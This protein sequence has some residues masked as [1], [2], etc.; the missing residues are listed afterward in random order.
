MVGEMSKQA[1]ASVVGSKVPTQS[2]LNGAKTTRPSLV[3]TA[4][5]NLEVP[6]LD[7]AVLAAQLKSLDSCRPRPGWMS[8]CVQGSVGM[9][10]LPE[11]GCVH[12]LPPPPMVAV[13]AHTVPGGPPGG[14]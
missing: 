1:K 10:K 4:S 14:A 12:H 6:R 13:A 3:A 5:P 11:Q 2:A 7:T 8:A 9:I